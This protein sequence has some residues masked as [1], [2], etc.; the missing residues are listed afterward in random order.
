MNKIFTLLL[1]TVFTNVFSQTADTIY[2]NSDWEKSEKKDAKFYRLTESKSDGTV[3]ANDY[4][5]KDNAPQMSGLFLTNKFEV[6]I[7]V[8]IYYYSTGDTSNVGAY[9]SIGEKTGLWKT[10]DFN[11]VL[12]CELTYQNGVVNGPGNDY[13][14]NGQLKE[15]TNFKNGDRTGWNQIYRKDGSLK[16]EREYLNGY[17]TGNYKKLSKDGKKQ[18]EVILEYE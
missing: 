6:K 16:L 15:S 4:Y 2:F 3:Y 8:F 13:Y 17:A 18:K 1:I 11:N 9:N 14:K 12:C 7:G 10:Y 5:L